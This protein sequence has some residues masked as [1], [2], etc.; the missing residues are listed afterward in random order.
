MYVLW[1]FIIL[2]YL[3]I[4]QSFSCKF[5]KFFLE[6]VFFK[7]FRAGM[8][9]F[10]FNKSLVHCILSMNFSDDLC[11]RFIIFMDF[12]MDKYSTFRK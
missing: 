6:T 7:N 5:F 1:I 12:S 8:I 11:K 9:K 2:Y 10:D 3:E 4:T